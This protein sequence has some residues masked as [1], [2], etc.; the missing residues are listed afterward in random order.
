M[1]VVNKEIKF[2]SKLQIEDSLN[3]FKKYHDSLITEIF[4]FQQQW[5]T[6]AFKRFKDFDKY[7]ILMYLINKAFKSY[8]EHFIVNSFDEFYSKDSF[9]L[10]KINI[11]DLS[12][13]LCISKETTRRK[14]MELELDGAIK[15]IKKKLCFK[16]KDKKFKNL[17][18]QL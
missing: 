16:E 5:L 11:I 6:A 14:M 18:T 3:V 1:S 8:N 7:I 10:P 13:E 4:Y 9:E 2:S 12:R 17:Q 15:K